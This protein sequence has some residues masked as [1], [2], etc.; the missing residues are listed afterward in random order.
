MKLE[1][2]KSSRKEKKYMMIFI[3]DGKRSKTT[4]FGASG[5]PDR[6]TTKNPTERKKRYTAYQSR[7]RGDNLNDMKSAGALSWY[8]L[9]AA[10]TI[11]GGIK[12][13]ENRFKVEVVNKI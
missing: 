5:Y 4:H 12:K 9:W 7:H 2:R 1:L 11:S 6:T 8:I 10:D 3:E 13:Y